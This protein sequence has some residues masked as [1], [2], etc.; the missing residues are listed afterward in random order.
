MPYFT[1]FI[2]KNCIGKQNK[3]MALFFLLS[4]I[5]YADFSYVR[6]TIMCSDLLSN[7][8]VDPDMSDS[9]AKTV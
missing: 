3:Q 4:L 8:P 6:I 9:W 5:I 2:S 1:A 7:G